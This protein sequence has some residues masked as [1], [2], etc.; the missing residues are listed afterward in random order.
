MTQG[1]VNSK[2]MKR[3]VSLGKVQK[4]SKKVHDAKVSR[5]AI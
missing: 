3:I 2:N 4:I 5:I 1:K